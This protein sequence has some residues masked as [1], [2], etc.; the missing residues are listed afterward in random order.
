MCRVKSSDKSYN[1]RSPSCRIL[2]RQPSINVLESVNFQI[3][4]LANWA[5]FAFLRRSRD[6]LKIP[7]HYFLKLFKIRFDSIRHEYKFGLINGL[8]L[9]ML[10]VLLQPRKEIFFLQLL[11]K[12]RSWL[13]LHVMMSCIKIQNLDLFLLF[14]SARSHSN[15]L[16]QISFSVHGSVKAKIPTSNTQLLY[17]KSNF[18][19]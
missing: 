2:N 4:I 17:N 15:V 1:E 3:F 7:Y 5:D 9:T 18:Q 14:F 13:N 8:R 10:I 19:R 12:N 16:L 6:A 11:L